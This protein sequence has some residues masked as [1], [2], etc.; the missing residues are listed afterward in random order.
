MPIFELAG[1]H[2]LVIALEDVVDS[3]T[4]K[5]LDVVELGWLLTVDEVFVQN[6]DVGL[7][8]IVVV[9]VV[10]FAFLHKGNFFSWQDVFANLVDMGNIFVDFVNH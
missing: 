1:N 6:L 5:I 4:A 9:V 3:R 7:V 8:A 2:E 10:L